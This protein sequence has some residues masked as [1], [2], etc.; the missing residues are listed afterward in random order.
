MDPILQSLKT[1]WGY[2]HFRYPQ[3][4]VITALLAKQDCLVVLPTGGGKS[5]CFQLPA[6]MGPGLT[7]V[8]SPLVA[9]MENQVQSLRAKQLPAACLH[10]QCGRQRKNQVLSLIQQ[11]RL[12]LL[13]CSPE[14]LLSPHIWEILRHPYLRLQGLMLDEAHCLVQW[15]DSFRPAYRRL[16]AVRAA[17]PLPNEVIPI[18]AF[19][20]TADP[21]QQAEICHALALRDPQRFQQSPYR[22][23]LH[24]QVQCQWSDHCRRHQG[25]K[26]I[27][28][29]AG[30]SGLVYVRTRQTAI[31]LAQWLQNQG[32]HTAPYHGGQASGLRRD[33]EKQWLAGTLPFVVCT[34]AFGLGINKPDTR[35]ILHYH[36]PL[37]LLEY[38]QEIGRAGRD[39]QPA[40]CLTLVSEPTGW[41][42]PGDRQRQQFF[43]RQQEQTQR[44]I[45]RLSSQLPRHGELLLLKQ[46][47]P[48]AELCLA[49]LHRQGQLQWDDPFHYRITS[50]AS[51]RQIITKLRQQYQQ[52][53]QYL[54]TRQCRWRFLLNIFHPETVHQNDCGHCDNCRQKNSA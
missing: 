39:Q 29:F 37:L 46:A 3:R 26:F 51:P 5:L 18:A 9:L 6:L 30:Q 10:S 11:Q 35:W 34:N 52:T 43:L 7:L 16:A 20:A 23:N 13:Y 12:K 33:L 40:T 32:C 2:D 44:K 21:Q 45:Q 28:R 47:F 14:T 25:L 53:K 19:T 8:V 17:L 41:L 22:P 4:E 27:R 49:W 1:Y 42:D 50:N 24:L 54:N 48:D 36:A 15:G 31:A 38:L